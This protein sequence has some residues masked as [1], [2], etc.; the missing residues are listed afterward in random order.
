MKQTTRTLLTSVLA[1][2]GGAA[3]LTAEPRR[4]LDLAVLTE[5]AEWI[6]LGRVSSIQKIEPAVTDRGPKLDSFGLVA[7]IAVERVL[8]G[9]STLQNAPVE[10]PAADVRAGA[11]R[12]A[13]GSYGMFF[14][15]QQ[16]RA[17]RLA[18]PAFPYLPALPGAAP[19]SG[20]TVDQVADTLS[21]VLASAEVSHDER[22]QSLDALAG[23]RTEY[24]AALLEQALG[25]SSKDVSWRI[26]AVLVARND[27]AGLP[28][29]QSLLLNSGGLPADEAAILSGSLQGLHDSRAVP[30][31]VR[32]FAANNPA[33]RLDVTI[34]LRQ[35]GSSAALNSLSQALSDSDQRVRYYGVAGLG[36]I[37][38]QNQW[39]PSLEEFK[40]NEDRYL[41]YW[42]RWTEVNLR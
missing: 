35:S 29:V 4:P 32:L 28:L 5:S 3:T 19:S 1:L 24:A 27:L 12:I 25:T 10:L 42:R 23:L 39:T 37:T 8:K 30:R 41:S 7:S 31:L 21:R 38:G 13:P 14:L 11:D 36:E 33:T 26:A 2:L 16:G 15:R 20:P 17:R 34:A 40:K 9:D 18:D 22:L 6:V